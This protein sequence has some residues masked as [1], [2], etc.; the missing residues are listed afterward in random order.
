MNKDTYKYIGYYL[1]GYIVLLVLYG[2]AQ[3]F[4]ICTNMEGFECNFSESKILAFLTVVAYI[5]TPM[6]AIVGFLNWK[7]QYKYQSQKERFNKLFETV[8][9]LNNEIKIL[10]NKD[11]T[12]RTINPNESSLEF[13]EFQEEK[14]NEFLKEISILENTYYESIA[15]LTILEFSLDIKMN[16]LR[17]IIE[18]HKITYEEF[19]NA[20]Y[21]YLY[22]LDKQH[23]L[24][25][26]ALHAKFSNNAESKEIQ[27]LLIEDRDKGTHD[28]I[29]QRVIRLNYRIQKYIS[30]IENYY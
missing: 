4:T 7:T 25:R 22:N 12:I 16:G 5:L 8:L 11:I 10:R 17:K 3:N 21:A 29:T 18:S 6:V 2:I 14:Y 13:S 28:S 30:K 26:N 24:L 9:R 15:H 27:K 23:Y 1:L 19:K 20:F